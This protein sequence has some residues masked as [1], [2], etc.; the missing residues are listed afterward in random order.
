M[1]MKRFLLMTMVLIAASVAWADHIQVSNRSMSFTESWSQPSSYFDYARA[2]GTVSWDAKNRILTLKD[3]YLDPHDSGTLDGSHQLSGLIINTFQSVTINVVGENHIV[4]ECG[5]ALELHGSVTFT[6]SGYIRFY[7]LDNKKPA[8]DVVQSSVKITVD[9]PHVKCCDGDYGI[10]G[11]NDTEIYLK[12]GKLEFPSGYGKL[13]RIGNVRYDYGM[14]VQQPHGAYFG[15]HG[16]AMFDK[17]NHRLGNDGAL[18]FGPIQYYG[19]KILD[20]WVTANN[21]DLLNTL[22]DG[23]MQRGNIQFQPSSN[24]LTLDGTTIENR[25]SG[26]TIDNAYNNSLKIVLKGENTFDFYGKG[27]GRYALET[28]AN[29]TIIGDATG[30]SKLTSSA[31]FAGVHIYGDNT[32]TLGNVKLDVPYMSS[33]MLQNASGKME[34][35][36]L[37]LDRGVEVNARGND[38]GN[39]TVRGMRINPATANLVVAVASDQNNPRFIN[40]AEYGVYE[41]ET[42]LATGA[43]TLSTMSD[44]ALYPLTICGQRVHS[45]NCKNP[46]NEY[47]KSGKLVYAPDE[48][49]L[50][51]DNAVLSVD[52]YSG[53]VL[54]WNSPGKL[55]IGLIG[56]SK[57]NNC[58]GKALISDGPVDVRSALHDNQKLVVTGTGGMMTVSGDKTLNLNLVEVSVPEIQAGR[59]ELIGTKQVDVTRKFNATTCELGMVKVASTVEA[60]AYYDA[61]KGTVVATKGPVSFFHSSLVTVFPGINFFGGEVN[62]INHT[63]LMSK[64]VTGGQIMVRQ[65][66]ANGFVIDM[67]G[68]QVWS[69]SVEN[70]FS[71]TSEGTSNI[72]IHGYNYIDLTGIDSHFVMS[73]MKNLYICGYDDEPNPS[74]T[75]NG[76][77]KANNSGAIAVAKGSKLCFQSNLS[78]VFD[79]NIQRIYGMGD[80]GVNTK[81]IVEKPY[82][83]VIGSSDGTVSNISVETVGAEL[84]SSS[85]QPRSVVSGNASKVNGVYQENDLCTGVVKFVGKGESAGYVAATGISLDKTSLTLNGLGST[86]TLKATV[87]PANATNKDVTWSSSDEAIVS[88]D[89]DGKLTAN[90]SG[91][92][93]IS[94]AANG[95]LAGAKAEC[96][97]TV[98]VPAV[99]SVAFDKTSLLFDDPSVNSQYLHVT[100]AP[101]GALKD[102]TWTSSD[103]TVVKI[104][105]TGLA[106]RIDRVADEGQAVITVKA[107]NGVSATCPV[108]VHYPITPK[109][110]D[111]LP[112]SVTLT[113]AGQKEVLTVLVTPENCDD[114][115]FEWVALPEEGDCVTFD[116]ETRT[117]TAVHNGSTTI[118]VWAT[119]KGQLR[120]LG[121]CVITVDIPVIAEKLELQSPSSFFYEYG[122]TITIMPLFTPTNTTNQQLTWKSNNESVATVTANGQVVSHSKGDATITATTTDGSNISASRLFTVYDPNDYRVVPATGITLDRESV[123]L[124]TGQRV[125]VNAQLYPDGACTQ[126]KW[127]ITETLQGNTNNVRVTWDPRKPRYSQ[128]CSVWYD[129]NEGVGELPVR[130]IVT[131][132]A[133]DYE[134]NMQPMASF[135][136]TIAEDIIFT[137]TNNDGIDIT[138]RVKDI[139]DESHPTCELYGQQVWVYKD[140]HGEFQY[141]SAIEPDAKDRIVIP[142]QVGH[143]GNF[144]WVDNANELAF[145]GHNKMEELVFPEGM[146]RLESKCGLEN[147]SLTTVTLPS[148][149][150][151]IN[152]E[153]F[154]ACPALQKVYMRSEK[155]PLGLYSMG[156]GIFEETESLGEAFAELPSDAQ[157]YVPKGSL[158]EYTVTQWIWNDWFSII[159]EIDYRELD[160]YFAD[161]NE[162]G[163]KLNYH[164]TSTDDKTCEVG[165][166]TSGA[167]IA[168]DVTEVEIPADVDGYAVTGIAPQA[169]VDKDNLENVTLPATIKTIGYGAF[170]SCSNLSDVYILSEMAP[171][172]LD[173][174][175]MPSDVNNYAFGGL[176]GA[177]ARAFGGFTLSSDPAPATLHVPHGC[178]K[179]YNKE[180]WNQWFSNIVDDVTSTSVKGDVNGDGVVDVADIAT[181]IDVMS[182][183]ASGSLADSADVNKDGTVDVADIATIIDEM[184]A[185]ARRLKMEEPQ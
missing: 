141:V 95:S 170:Y 64:D 20:E 124:F 31:S 30:T 62:S 27:G 74:L 163:T 77:G 40:N 83:T 65:E 22:G 91:E 49:S 70:M 3:L 87:S 47:V 116:P 125:N 16:K 86:A 63:C 179:A 122:D 144:Y 37:V 39:G 105:D 106:A 4:V 102:V 6:G 148:T 12:K 168:D 151:S 35:G 154:K 43:V 104:A 1:T 21:W 14:G 171:T 33:S 184:A 157:L 58:K 119:Y 54:Y 140:G 178:L 156:S 36:T 165:G 111:F 177:E 90:G 96:R 81:L 176:P 99:T 155:S 182:G 121:E 71:L 114:L 175:D 45:L 160:L 80:N 41:S 69:K 60:P 169:F 18:V 13:Y 46:I 118:G 123:M 128:T 126:V 100:I 150:R 94:A 10:R 85:A 127:E 136:V 68:A 84:F 167:A 88:V 115:G 25:S 162:E 15:S 133:T 158:N 139:R 97:V 51:M 152:I 135:E 89:K 19:F 120:A 67:R 53:D 149:I 17:D 164:I 103:T 117:V 137:A 38:S 93:I 146:T 153:A 29:T 113:E 66:D 44:V 143:E 185:N 11:C 9:G 73:N 48:H 24:T 34:S 183:S 78:Q 174:D 50:Y 32:L 172:L 42:K 5:Q 57:I 55:T 110:V 108:T 52:G 2:G 145:Y 159:E 61:E 166:K 173:I 28:S 7:N 107:S 161:T 109:R 75:V 112:A 79:A 142:S 23:S 132:K 26:S 101:E 138:Y 59:V 180:P 82:L 131:A 72:N 56:E 147:T 92:A 181:V 76:K 98:S 130:F 129:T 8:I 134:G